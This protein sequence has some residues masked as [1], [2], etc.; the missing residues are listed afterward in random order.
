MAA[1]ALLV[2]VVT[3]T[4]L[5]TSVQAS[6]SITC[7]AGTGSLTMSWSGQTHIFQYTAYVKN[8]ANQQTSQILPW[9]SRSGTA[10]VTFSSLS[11]GDYSVWVV[12]QTN[13]GTWIRFGDTTCTVSESAPTTTTTAPATT[14]TTEPAEGSPGSL[15]CSASASSITVD[16]TLSETAAST[17]TSW[18]VSLAHSSGYP[19]H[20]QI[21]TLQSSGIDLDD[22]GEDDI[23]FTPVYSVTF[24]DLAQGRWDAN[25]WVYFPDSTLGSALSG[26]SCTVAGGL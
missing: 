4:L 12:K 18:E 2:A 22:D 23:T 13:D 24:Q 6:G 5:T 16:L 17:A 25:G 26:T 7:S 19:S 10:S 9:R 3:G 21:S 14:T 15:S 1:S 11:A 8:S 20:G